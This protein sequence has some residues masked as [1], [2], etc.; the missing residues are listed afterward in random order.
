MHG[1]QSI[2]KCREKYQFTSNSSIIILTTS[3]FHW[4]LY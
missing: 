1:Q 3:A 2:K 4:P